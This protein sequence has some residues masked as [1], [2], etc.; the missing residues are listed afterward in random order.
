[1]RILRRE[2]DE[3][4]LPAHFRRFI[5]LLIAAVVLAGPATAGQWHFDG[6]E[7]VVAI[8]DIHGAY[9]PM[10]R[11]LRSA[12]VLDEG[13][14]WSAG[15][16]HLVIVGDILDRGPESRPAMDLLMRLERE[17]VAAGGMV[18]VLI[19]NHEAM[20]L[21]GDLRYVS[22]SEYAAFAAEE[23]AVEREHW[24]KAFTERRAP[25]GKSPEEVRELFDRSFPE[26]FFAHREAF[27]P[28]GKYGEWLLQKPIMIVINGTAY[29]HGGVSPMIGKVGLDGVNGTLHGE[30]VD[31]VDHLE[32]LFDSGALLPTDN[33]YQHPGILEKYMPPLDTSVE[34][35]DA[36]A[37]VK[38]LNDSSLH[39]PDGPLWY[40]GNVYCGALIEA[41]RLDAVL[42]S[43]GAR[44]VVIGHTPTSNRR[45]LERFNGT[46]IEVDTGM[47][48]AYYKGSGNAVVIEGDEI[49]VINEASSEV[50]GVVRHPR[51]VGQRPA[52]Y[53]E[54]G[55]IEALLANGDV[56]STVTDESGTLIVTVS[57]GE[58]SLEA[59][60]SKNVG[61]G[62][63]PEAAAYRLDLLLE[64]DMVPV[65]VQR[66][67]KRSEGTL[68]F[69]V[70][71]SLDEQQRQEKGYGGGA[72]CPLHDQ[73]D[74]MFIF[75]AL[76]HNNGRYMRTI[77]YSP[78]TWQLLLVGHNEAFATSKGR[79]RHL[80]DRQLVL[81]QRWRAALEA[82]TD[83]VLV[84]HFGDVLGTRRISALGKRRDE[85]LALP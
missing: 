30:M 82:L 9:K 33:F 62:V 59:V 24:F 11:T 79:P 45:I 18:H 61:R 22:R 71:G 51:R 85:L 29:V 6:I 66:K 70:P 31:Y 32:V 42:A 81:N 83:D 15:K 28:D 55:D 49:S 7:R 4:N 17:A 26:G 58:N 78:D 69:K 48:G 3:I 40:R 50:L 25:P 65:T 60:F 19:G 72:L 14:S 41:D 63:S 13:L 43:I 38:R 53:M 54:A 12:G 5:A 16:T 23:R 77:Q 52:E 68:Q 80:K 37:A 34:V 73:W 1:M 46:V 47:F 74:A 76:I 36:I 2:K 21:I 56:V 35:L 44:R 67:I 84:E 57:D 75:D 27:G 10:V 64:L 39:A 20:N 8:S